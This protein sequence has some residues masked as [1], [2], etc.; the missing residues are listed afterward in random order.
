MKRDNHSKLIPAH[1]MQMRMKG[2][3][4]HQAEQQLIEFGQIHQTQ[5]SKY[6]DVADVGFHNSCYENFRS[7]S[8]RKNM[9]DKRKQNDD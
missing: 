6:R 3:D 2:E 1:T 4:L 9:V 5:N 8:W 7:P